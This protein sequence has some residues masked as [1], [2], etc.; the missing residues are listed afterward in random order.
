MR[1]KINSGLLNKMGVIAYEF[2]IITSSIGT[3]TRLRMLATSRELAWEKV[4]RLHPRAVEYSEFAEPTQ[5]SSL[6][7]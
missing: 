3:R 2:E 5:F 4:L 7:Y 1:K 6:R